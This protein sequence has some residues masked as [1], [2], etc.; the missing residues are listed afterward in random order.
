M[1]FYEDQK[2]LSEML[3]NSIDEY[4]FRKHPP[5]FR[6]HLGGS[7]IGN[8][9]SR[10][11][12][13]GF[14]WAK[15][16][17]HDAKK[18]RVFNRG[19]REEP[20]LIDY[21]RGI[22]CEVQE[23]DVFTG[24]QFRV[25]HCQGHFG[26]SLDGKVVLPEQFDKSRTR[27]ILEMKLLDQKYFLPYLKKPVQEISS[28]YYDQT[29]VYGV[30]SGISSALF[31]VVNKSSNKQNEDLAVQIVQLDMQRGE[32]LLVKAAEVI[33]AETPPKGVG[34]RSSDYRCKMCDYSNLCWT[35]ADSDSPK[36]CR[37]CNCA[38][39]ADDAQWKCVK[40]GII[41]DDFMLKGCSKFRN[42]CYEL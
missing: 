7:V 2:E 21:L 1:S 38:E 36:N 6:K 24:N 3:K 41:P 4:C 33:Y 40:Y 28:R 37:C 8:E 26:G 18:L 34:S 12:W 14:R 25:S 10:A 35:V 30:L 13:Y 31:V 27:H 29:C 19:H 15:L 32:E 20:V 5:K 17:K 11:L 23:G 39:P 9:C 42:I 16:V 22:G